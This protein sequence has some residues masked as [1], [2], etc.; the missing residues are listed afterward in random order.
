MISLVRGVVKRRKF[1]RFLN[2]FTFNK[3]L[4]FIFFCWGENNGMVAQGVLCLSLQFQDSPLGYSIRS[5]C[6]N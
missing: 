5:V 1:A 6:F 4:S 3:F 2:D